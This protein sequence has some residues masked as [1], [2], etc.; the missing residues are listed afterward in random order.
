MRTM[1]EAIEKTNVLVIVNT[2]RG[3]FDPFSNVH[4][5][6]EQCHNLLNFRYTGMLEFLLRISYYILRIPSTQAPNRK[7]RLQTFSEK[8]VYS[9]TRM[10]Q[11]EKDRWLVVA[12]IK[13]I[14]Y[15]KQTS[16]P[17]ERL[18]EQLLE[19]PLSLCDTEG[20]P[21]KGQKTYITNA[22]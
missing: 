6:E 14:Q 1:I 7:H 11:L 2:N 19:Y 3:L 20:R 16:T 18:G 21:L 22:L 9:K 8:Q 10:T 12:A 15:S 4:A 17:I 5:M 13:K